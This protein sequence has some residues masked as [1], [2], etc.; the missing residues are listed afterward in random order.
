MIF[1]CRCFLLPC[2]K[3]IRPK[4]G[5]GSF[6][7]ISS[8]QVGMSDEKRITTMRTP[9][10][11]F[12]KNKP[13]IAKVVHEHEFFQCFIEPTKISGDS[14][15]AGGSL[16]GPLFRPKGEI[17]AGIE[18]SNSHVSYHGQ[19]KK[20]VGCMHIMPLLHEVQRRNHSQKEK[21]AR[22]KPGNKTGKPW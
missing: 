6:F 18:R 2:L 17:H 8:S 15:S 19:L 4:V 13:N 11:F 12:G 3:L 20:K 10:D 7:K 22:K 16:F 14:E 21:T 1:S 5:G 9:Q